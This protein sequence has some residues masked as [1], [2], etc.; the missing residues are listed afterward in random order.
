MKSKLKNFDD[1]REFLNRIPCINSGGC[2]ISALT[3]YRWVK[4][5]MPEHKRRITFYFFHKDVYDYQNNI[6]LIKTKKYRNNKIYVPSHIGIK[7]KNVTS[8]VIDSD[9]IVDSNRFGFVIKTKS[10]QVLINALKNFK[11]WNFLFERNKSISLIEK[12]LDI[13]LSDV[14]QHDTDD[15][16]W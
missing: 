10:E 16:I 13:D 5:N 3:M 14:I 15:F 8:K 11:S 7:I 12:H 4:K 6:T 9:G 1:V 2:G